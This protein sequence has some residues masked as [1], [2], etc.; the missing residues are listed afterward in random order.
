VARTDAEIAANY[1]VELN[2]AVPRLVG[3]WHFREG[4][5]NTA[6]DSTATQANFMLLGGADWSTDSPFT[7]APAPAALGCEPPAL[8]IPFTGES[9]EVLLLFH[10]LRQRNVFENVPKSTHVVLQLIV[11]G[12]HP[13]RLKRDVWRVRL[14]DWDHP[15]VLTWVRQ[16]GW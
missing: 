8:G 11:A 2:E 12:G 3:N 4:T 1:Q 16:T 13:L 6:F 14:L 15:A 7:E 9:P 10:G 5:G